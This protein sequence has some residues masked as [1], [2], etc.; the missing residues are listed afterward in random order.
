MKNPVWLYGKVLHGNQ[1]GRKIG[2]PTINLDPKII[3]SNLKEGVYASKV[4]CDNKLY[5]GALFYGPRLINNELHSVLEIHI[6]DFDENI[7][8]D[9]IAFQIRD[10]IRPVLDFTTFKDLQEE[11]HR[12]VLKVKEVLSQKS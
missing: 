3:T 10:Y 1:D 11:I 7:Y 8:G 5:N 9:T 2:F 4:Q 12:D 6:L